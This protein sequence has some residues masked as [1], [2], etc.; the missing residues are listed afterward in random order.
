MAHTTSIVSTLQS[1]IKNRLTNSHIKWSISILSLVRLVK[2]VLSMLHH[3]KY[4][5][6][7]A[8]RPRLTK[9]SYGVFNESH[10]QICGE[11][12]TFRFDTVQT[13]IDNLFGGNDLYVS[14]DR[15]AGYE[16]PRS[17]AALAVYEN[18]EVNEVSLIRLLNFDLTHLMEFHSN[19]VMRWGY[20][21]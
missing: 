17:S 14:V 19:G 1:K 21:E 16:V 11:K 13:Y 12:E 6:Y 8:S 15:N 7:N 5:D 3:P 4:A 18:L 20:L 9:G 10:W 2:H